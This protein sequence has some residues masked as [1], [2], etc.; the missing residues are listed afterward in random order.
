MSEELT[1]L[2]MQ[3][4]KVARSQGPWWSLVVIAAKR[5]FCLLHSP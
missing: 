4:A 3:A 5:L 1:V 2:E